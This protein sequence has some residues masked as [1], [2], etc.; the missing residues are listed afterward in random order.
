[1]PI[2]ENVKLQKPKE[3]KLS[4]N[5]EVITIG[6]LAHIFL[7]F[8]SLSNFFIIINNTSLNLVYKS[9]CQFISLS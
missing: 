2:G 5:V 6:I 3:N 7:I 8:C 1:M 9:S 4:V